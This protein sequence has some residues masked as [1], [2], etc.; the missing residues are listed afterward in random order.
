[1]KKLFSTFLIASFG[2]GMA[3]AQTVLMSEDFGSGTIPA[4]WSNVGTASGGNAAAVKFHY[5]SNQT[6]GSGGYYGNSYGTIS[7]PTKSNG[8]ITFDSDSLDEGTSGNEATGVAPG[9]Q[10]CELTTSAIN[11]AGYPRVRVTF[12]QYMANYQA[13]TAVAYSNDSIHWTID[14]LNAN[15]SGNSATAAADERVSKDVSSIING[16]NNLYIRFI[17]DGNYYF[18]A[19]DDISVVELPVNDLAITDFA[20]VSLTSQGLNLASYAYP[21]SQIDS[22]TAVVYYQNAGRAD[23]PNVVSNITVKKANT[24]VSSYSTTPPYSVVPTNTDTFDYAT[25][26]V[27]GVGN[28]KSYVTV[29]SDS[30]DY[31]PTNNVDSFS[32]VIND[33]IYSINTNSITGGYF[34]TRPNYSLD[35][36]YGTIFEVLHDDTVSSVT[37]AFL[38]GTRYTHPGAIV[39]AYIYPVTVDLNAGSLTLS[40]LAVAT[41]QKTLTSAQ[42]S[43]STS[44]FRTANLKIDNRSGNP[45]LT[46]GLYYLSI[47]GVSGGPNPADSNILILTTSY[48]ENGFPTIEDGGNPGNIG[49]FSST[50]APYCTIN[51]GHGF[52][53]LWAD[54]ARTPSTSPLYVGHVVQYTGQSNGNAAT[55]TYSWQVTGLQSGYYRTASTKIWKDTLT[56]VDDSMQV[57]LTVT[58]GGNTATNCKIIRVR[59]NVGINDIQTVSAFNMVPNP[60]TGAVTISAEGVSGATTITLTNMLGEVVKHYNETAN[61]TFSKPYNVSDLSS[62]VYIVK[63][64]NGDNSSTKRLSISK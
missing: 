20:N 58:D 5:T 40:N 63:I 50:D 54:F 33:S 15:L 24:Q 13:V 64:Q 61:G 46:P 55:A 45:V 43:P 12:Y 25:L 49:Y 39:Q 56:A 4:G 6:A 30:I 59:D 29:S 53:T 62:G 44:S 52:N 60:T 1:M 3:Q 27:N 23:Q 17:W 41:E 22:V 47:F 9:P 7:S 11:V 2:F 26:G 28:Y 32:F 35:Y 51:F 34:M 42:I 10:H 57:C 48:Q 16:G 37:T 36:R 18:W 38:G 19:L 21:L 14:T 31:D 8:Y